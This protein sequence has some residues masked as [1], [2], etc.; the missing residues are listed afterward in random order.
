MNSNSNA[1]QE[2]FNW[3]P[4]ESDPEIFTDY[5]QKIGLPQNFSFKEIFALDYKEIQQIDTPVLAV[6][7]SY[8]RIKG[9]NIERKPENFLNY[10]SVPYFMKQTNS[11]DNACGIIAAIH[12]IGNNLEEIKLGHN[13]ILCNFFNSVKQKNDLDRAK[14]LENYNDMKTAHQLYANQGQSNLCESQEHV[15]NH[16]V[17]FVYYNGNLIEYDGLLIGPYIIKH[18]IKQED[19]L[20]ESIA[21]VKNR[22]ENNL[23]TE[24]LAL[25]YL[26]K[27]NQ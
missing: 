6:I 24:N 11:L 27:D 12:S 13:S 20:D 22:L 9:S 19:L 18:N 14:S 7:V 26:T 23:I 25:M 5:T 17:A 10:E 8:E 2:V 15:R 3:P 16:F 4:L 21:E 1:E